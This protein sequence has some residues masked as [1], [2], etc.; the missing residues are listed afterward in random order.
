SDRNLYLASMQLVQQAWEEGAMDRVRDLL[1]RQRPEW[2]GGTDYRG[3]EW[4]YWWRCLHT[5][6]HTIL[7]GTYSTSAA[8]SPDGKFLARSTH[9]GVTIGA[10]GPGREARSIP[11][12]PSPWPHHVAYSRAGQRLAVTSL[13]SLKLFD[14]Q[15]GAEKLAVPLGP[16]HEVRGP[17]FRP[18]GAR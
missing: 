8:C 9:H 1:E 11:I 13:G 5:D 15:T 7:A 6:L 3:F 2:T 18:D 12:Y 4:H 17:A 14:P 10:G 16:A